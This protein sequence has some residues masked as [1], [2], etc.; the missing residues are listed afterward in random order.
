MDEEEGRPGGGAEDGSE[1]IPKSR[2]DARSG[3]RGELALRGC[4]HVI[5]MTCEIM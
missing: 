4:K 2:D 1:G 5:W 3:C